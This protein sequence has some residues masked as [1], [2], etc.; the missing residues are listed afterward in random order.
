MKIGL[1]ESKTNYARRVIKPLLCPVHGKSARLSFEYDR[2]E[3]ATP[4]ISRCCCLEFA[5]TVANALYETNMFDV[6]Y[7]EDKSSLTPK[8]RII[9]YDGLD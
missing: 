4:Q 6:V 3:N 8:T 2:D 7:L 5:Q 1:F 9:E